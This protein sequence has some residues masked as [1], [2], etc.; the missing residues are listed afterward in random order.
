LYTYSYGTTTL[1]TAYT[2]PTA[3]TPHTYTSDGLGGSYIALN[4]RGEL[5]APLYLTAGAYDLC[6]KT[7]AGATVWTRRADPMATDA[8][9]LRTDLASTATSKG[10]A[11]VGAI[12]RLTSATARTQEAKNS[13][14][15]NVRDF[16]AVLNGSTDDRTAI[17]AALNSGAV[18]VRINGIGAISGY[19]TVP[20]GVRFVGAGQSSGVLATAAMTAYAPFGSAHQGQMVL[21]IGA[22]A[23]C[24]NMRLNGGNFTSGGVAVAATAQNKIEGN[25]ITNCGVSQ[26]VL[27]TG[28]LDTSVQRNFVQYAQH[29]IQAWQTNRTAIVGNIVRVMSSG[30]IWTADTANCQI[31]GNVTSDCGDVGLDIE[32]GINNSITGNTAYSC[33]NGEIAWFNNGTGSGR[34]PLN[35]TISGN[36]AYR[37]AT[38]LAGTTETVTATSSTFAGLTIFTVTSGQQ[39]ITFKA[40]TV[41]ATGRTALFTNDLGAVYTG[42]TI[43][44]NV[45]VSDSLLHNVQ[46]A[47]GIQVVNNTFK[48]VGATVAAAQNFFKNCSAALWDLNTYEFDTAKNT[49]P[50]LYYYTDVAITTGPTI[51]R[52]KFRNCGAFAFK[53]DPFTSGVSAIVS[54][55]LFSD[56]YVS[57]GG[58]ESTANGYP[59]YR[60]QKLYVLINDGTATPSKDLGTLTAIAASSITSKIQLQVWSGGTR[61]AYYDLI[62]IYSSNVFSRDGSGNPSGIVANAARYGTFTGS[63]VALTGPS[64]GT[65]GFLVLDV[66]S[67]S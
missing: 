20:A 44:G 21:L 66:N 1:K 58:V 29:G 54:E 43:E 17:Q 30:G 39:G 15:V 9:A 23:T 41:Y 10:A 62:Y 38:Y 2:E 12:Q 25:W 45:F 6:L 4:A 48:G 14:F 57:N 34:V 52:N 19:L 24:E 65:S 32:G 26:A 7:S 22:G 18:E 42:I 8:D 53:H 11:L 33:C 31:T 5:P 13:D 59:T 28:S 67:F 56:S 50:A 35:N 3:T 27:L 47:Y 60:N 64:V 61:G 37:T 16:G 46:R 63:S 55:N 40:N 51:S 36:V 49:T